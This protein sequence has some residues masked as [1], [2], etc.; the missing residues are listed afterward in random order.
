VPQFYA[1]GVDG[2]PRE[3]IRRMKASMREVGKRFSCHRMLREYAERFYLPGLAAGASHAG[4]GHAAV[5]NLAG[6][7]D[8]VRRSWPGLRVEGLSSSSPSILKVGDTITVRAKVHLAGMSPDDVCV[9]LYHGPLSSQG[10]IREPRRLAMQPL[11]T[12]GAATVYGADAPADATGRQGYT[13]RVL[14][15]HPALV[16]PFLPGLVK[17]G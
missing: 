12:E 5:K 3:W 16:H 11:G 6:Y 10:E 8:R 17:W 15:R 2:L 1:R 13:L 9:E 4:G 14:P 7:L